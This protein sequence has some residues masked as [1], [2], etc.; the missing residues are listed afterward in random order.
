MKK[1]LV[2]LFIFISFLGFSQK[3]KVKKDIILLNEKEIAKMDTEGETYLFQDLNDI[4]LAKISF[5]AREA[6]SSITEL[7]VNVSNP[8]GTISNEVSFVPSL[9]LNP[10]KMLAGFIRDELNF[11]DLNGIKTDEITTFFN[12][13]TVRKDKEKYDKVIA[14]DQK[15]NEWV[16]QFSINSNNGI[17]TKVNSNKI[18]SYIIL[19]N[20]DNTNPKHASLVILD[21][22]KEVIA[23]ID[24]H[25]DKTVSALGALG[26]QISEGLSKDLDVKRFDNKLSYINLDIQKI[27]NRDDFYRV[28]LKQMYDSGYE[29]IF[30]IGV[31]ALKKL[32]FERAVEEYNKRIAN[33]KNIFD[34]K[35][36]VL[37]KG[38]PRREGYIT[39]YVEDIPIP[40]GM[41]NP[42]DSHMIAINGKNTGKRMRFLEL[43]DEKSGSYRFYRGK[44]DVKFCIYLEEGKEECYQGDKYNFKKIN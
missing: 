15:A 10:K 9:T 19:N 31:T 1:I 40:K 41:K 43:K 20:P 42:E 23:T 18:V 21:G 3:L 11:F 33:S 17:I 22:D 34:K 2:L 32:N 27:Q 36:Y 30:N 35:G 5:S 37:T 8:E 44:K 12:S 6:T 28:V 25:E 24:P 7:W 26:V 13:K 29:E 4:T 16:S 14:S 38:D 39:F